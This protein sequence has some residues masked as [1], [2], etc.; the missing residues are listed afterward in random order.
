MNEWYI[1]KWNENGGIDV[2]KIAKELWDWVV[3]F[4]VV[5]IIVFIVRTFLFAN[6]MV[7]GESM[8]PTIESGERLIINK[9]GYEF[10]EPDRNDLIVFNATEES[11]YIKRVIG[12]PGDD[13]RYEDDT[14]YINDEA[15]EEPFLDDAYNG[16]ITEDFTLEEVTSE[17]IVPDDH[18]FVLGDNRNNSQD[19]RSIGFVPYEDVVG[20]ASLRYWPLDEFTF[21][22]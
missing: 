6:Y 12:I 9:I 20:E 3:T 5:I 11:D 10:S 7:H 4:A 8:M 21:I 19:S 13:I 18:L 2:N 15:V 16:E 22:D 17:S 1:N 14:L